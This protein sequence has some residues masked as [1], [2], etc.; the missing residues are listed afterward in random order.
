VL[1]SRRGADL[2]PQLLQNA[3]RLARSVTYEGTNLPPS[4]AFAPLGENGRCIR[5]DIDLEL[6]DEEVLQ[7]WA[8]PGTTDREM[9]GG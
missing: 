3:D 1:A 8:H 5:K 2:V 7:A 6:V 4:P 9:Q